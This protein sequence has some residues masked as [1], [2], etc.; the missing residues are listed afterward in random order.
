MVKNE[1]KKVKRKLADVKNVRKKLRSDVTRTKRNFFLILVAGVGTK[2]G[3][4]VMGAGIGYV[5]EKIIATIS[6]MGKKNKRTAIMSEEQLRIVELK[7][8]ENQ[9]ELDRVLDL[10]KS[11]A[12]DLKNL[13]DRELGKKEGGPQILTYLSK[14]V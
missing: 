2:L 9:I 14:Y 3:D 10:V 12:T 11:K 4:W 5:K 13:A 7:T 8:P 1:I 6:D